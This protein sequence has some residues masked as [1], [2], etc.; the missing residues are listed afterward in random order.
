VSRW[1]ATKAKLVY[2]ALLRNGWTFKRQSGGSHRILERAGWQDYT[3]A[4]HDS[5][6]IGPKA[7]AKL[8]KQTGLGPNDL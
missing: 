4:Y 5:E 8:A 7:L 1:P 2:K 6:E 3:F